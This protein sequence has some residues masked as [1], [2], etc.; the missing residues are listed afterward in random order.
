MHKRIR[1][2]FTIVELVIVIAVIGIL[3]A[4]TIAAYKGTQD[5]ARATAIISG[6]KNVDE[7]FRLVAAKQNTNTWWIDNAFNG[8]GNPY[9]SDILDPASTVGTQTS[10]ATSLQ[11]YLP[12]QPTVNGLS[13]AWMYDNDAGANGIRT[14]G[15]CGGAWSGAVLAVSNVPAS[16]GA[17]VDKMIDD[18]DPLC[19]DVLISGTTVMYQL[20]YSPAME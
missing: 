19:G 18:G 17:Q 3:A 8:V 11:S 12:S 5:R 15:V 10:L 14:V 2:G 9:L 13:L 16:V 20:S 6:I 7:A 1:S 4:I